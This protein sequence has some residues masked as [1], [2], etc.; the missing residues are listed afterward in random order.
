MLVYFY[1]H[2]EYFKAI[3]YNLWQFGIVCGYLVYFSP[4]WYFVPRKIWQPW[5]GVKV[6]RRSAHPNPLSFSKNESNWIKKDERKGI[7]RKKVT[8]WQ[9]KKTNR[10]Q[11][12]RKTRKINTKIDSLKT[13]I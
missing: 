2:L 12:G 10:K 13:G 3:W 5:V 1:G 6:R 9:G 4:F 11:I 8:V 7:R